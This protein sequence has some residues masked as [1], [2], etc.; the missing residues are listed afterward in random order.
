MS[1]LSSD[2]LPSRLPSDSRIYVTG[3]AGLVG[4]AIW[5]HLC[6]QGFTELIGL[7]SSELD[8]RERSPV[9]DFFDQHRPDYVIMAAARV[10]GIVANNTR[11]TE[12][13]SDNLRIQVNVLDA[14]RRFK[15]KRLLFLGSSCIYP[16]YAAQPMQEEDLLTGRLEPTNEA[17]GI[18]KLAGI[19]HVQAIRRQYGLP[20]ISALPT[21]L[22][23]PK[24]NFDPITSHVLPA[25][26]RNLHEAKAANRPA[27]RL[28]G[29]GRPRRE[30]LHVDD[31]AKA[32]LVLL[33]RYDD[34]LPVNIGTGV[35]LTI[36]ELATTV[37]SVVG[38]EGQIMWD[39]SM[40]DGTPR[41]LLDISRIR[42]LGWS[43]TISLEDGIAGTYAWFLA[44]RTG[45]T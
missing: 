36:S 33:E 3:H 22:Y 14:A 39:H 7:R 28:W 43:P 26:I 10:G 45:Q 2:F 9:F 37:A 12:F 40:P 30:F 16:K 21:N 19:L 42:D 41:K 17:Y 11:P 5:R 27:V 18:A 34:K 38:F 44:S 23:G 24:D 32:C 25:L 35:D 15:S 8:L 20:F 4:S 13:L 1:E 31:L 6:S 29:T